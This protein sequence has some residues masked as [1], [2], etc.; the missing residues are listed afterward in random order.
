[1]L[2]ALIETIVIGYNCLAQPVGPG[3]M[4]RSEGRYDCSAAPLI[5]HPQAHESPDLQPAG[6]IQLEKVVLLCRDDDFAVMV[7]R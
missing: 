4:F 2:K 3:L 1:V 6:R 5:C 7:V